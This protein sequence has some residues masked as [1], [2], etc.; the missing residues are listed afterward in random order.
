MPTKPQKLTKVVSTELKT[1][2]KNTH[3]VSACLPAILE[4]YFLCRDQSDGLAYS[5]TLYKPVTFV[6]VRTG[7]I[8]GYFTI[9]RI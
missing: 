4:I 3:D 8:E 1:R 7:N 6:I 2:R 9:C 5:S